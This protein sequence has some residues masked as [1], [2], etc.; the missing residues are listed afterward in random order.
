[1]T[2]SSTHFYRY[3]FIG[4]AVTAS[5]LLTQMVPVFGAS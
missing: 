1:M 3:F 2:S 5:M 4:F